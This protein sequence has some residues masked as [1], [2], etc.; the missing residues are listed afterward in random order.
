MTSKSVVE[1]AGSESG[2]QRAME[3]RPGRS[4]VEAYFVGESPCPPTLHS[5]GEERNVIH[6]TALQWQISADFFEALAS[7]KLAGAG[8]V[9]DVDE[10]IIVC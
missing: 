5:R 7:K 9:L 2:F 8:H 6:A 4:M 3:S 1:T 10:T